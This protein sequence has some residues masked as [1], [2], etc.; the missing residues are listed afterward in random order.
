MLKKHPL[1]VFVAVALS[2]LNST[3]ATN[4][5]EPV[6]EVYVV[7]GHQARFKANSNETAMRMDVSQLETAG[8]VAVMDQTLIQEQNATTLGDVLVNDA[9]I[10]V[11]GTDRNREI[12]MLRG[13]ELDTG[14][15]YL[16]NGQQQWSY[17]R[18]P[19]ELMERVEVLKGPAGLL[20]GKSAPG[21][22]VNMVTK[23][24]TAAFQAS[25]SQKVG[26]N[27]YQ[28][29]VADAS[30]SLNQSGTLRGRMVLSKQSEGSSRRYL[31]GSEPELDRQ[32]A[33]LM[34][35][36]DIT[37]D[38][39]LSL[40]YDRVID[41][42]NSDNGA[43]IINGKPQLGSQFIWEAPWSFM[44]I[45]VENYGVDI[46]SQLTPDW[47]VK[48]GYNRQDYERHYHEGFGYRGEGKNN[49]YDPATQTFEYFAMDRHDNWVLDTAYADITG[50]FDANQINHQVLVGMNGLRNDYVGQR[51]FY[52]DKTDNDKD[53]APLIAQIGGAY[54]EP[55]IRYQDKEP[56]NPDATYS[57]GIYAQDLMTL[58]P[59]WQVLAGLRYDRE[60]NETDTYYNLLPKAAVMYHPTPEQTLYV[61]YSESFEPKNP[62]DSNNDIN[63]GMALDPVK[64]KLYELGYK[65]ALLN[66]QALFSAAVFQIEQEN[67]IV[68]ETISKDISRTTQLGK[69][70][71]KGVE[72]NLGG[73]VTDSW[74]LH[75]SATYLHARTEDP[76]DPKH[77]GKQPADTP[78]WGASI[79]SRYDVDN[80]TYVNLGARYVGD[81]YG[82]TKNTYHKPG[83]TTVNA[84]VGHTVQTGE[85]SDLKLTVNVKN[86][87]NE[88]YLAGGVQNKTTLGEERK[89]VVG[90]S[91]QF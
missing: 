26:T 35:D 54:P 18:H 53:D 5:T 71:H 50:K 66:D 23:R 31:D 19:V 4:P 62:V 27:D 49:T 79:W 22:L 9:S 25:I 28:H 69:Q 75:S 38:T 57:T 43:N 10:G 24:P 30:G 59:Q 72:L 51:Y 85:R 67:I 15:G 68:T 7:E 83:Y 60:E 39:Q 11:G 81:R 6:D 64:G 3:A 82:D 21:G 14:T 78:E 55:D 32:I 45:D 46:V 77:D 65:Q 52:K 76:F 40:H 90:A 2:P 47:K 36:Y 34:L 48:A 29:T 16:R 41:D 87:F 89:V 88:D 12:F 91:L 80:Q 73:Q 8:Q 63:D 13:F 74:S 37:P 86:L 58:N 17:Y 42:S 44:D 20:Y 33:G 84:G 70:I 56:R 61:T 1:A